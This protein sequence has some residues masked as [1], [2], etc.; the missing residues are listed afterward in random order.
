MTGAQSGGPNFDWLMSVWW[1]DSGEAWPRVAR[2]L[3]GWVLR[4]GRLV[5]GALRQGWLVEE[6]LLA[7]AVENSLGGVQG[8]AMVVQVQA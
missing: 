2:W 7:V 3:A 6:V 8:E 1:A 4:L 5:K